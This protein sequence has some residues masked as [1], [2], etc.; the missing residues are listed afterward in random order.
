MEFSIEKLMRSL[1]LLFH[2]HLPVA[3][4]ALVTKIDLLDIDSRAQKVSTN[5][6]SSFQSQDIEWSYCALSSFI[7]VIALWRYDTSTDPLEVFACV[8][9]IFMDRDAATFMALQNSTFEKFITLDS[10]QDQ[11]KGVTS[12]GWEHINYGARTTKCV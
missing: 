11:E 5:S 2:V 7:D 1:S 4:Q 8:H 3:K 12:Q 6:E 9:E 10:V